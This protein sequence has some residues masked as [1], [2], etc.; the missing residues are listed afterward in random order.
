MEGTRLKT[1]LTEIHNRLAPKYGDGEAREM[2]RII[3]ENLKGWNPVDL[4][5]RRDELVS[6]YI[7]GKVQAVVNRLLDDEPIQQIFGNTR[8]YGLS[9]KVTTDT[10]I[11]RQETA[12][13]V[14][15]I[16]KENQR[17]DLRVLDAGT[18]TGCI[19]LAL[20]R[21]LNFPQVIATDISDKALAV[22][23]EN[24][25]ALRTNQVKFVNVDIL[26]MPSSVSQGI[27][28]S[29]SLP[30]WAGD[31][32]FDIIVSNPPYIAEH[33][34]AS[35]ERNVLDFEPHIALFVPDSD[36]LRFYTAI[37]SAAVSG[38]LRQGGKLY[39][40]INPIYSESLVSVARK[41]GLDNVSLI[42]DTN[43]KLRFLTATR[44]ATT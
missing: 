28:G 42:R 4:A 5:I 36:P 33:E 40:E 43:G 12:E 37:I 15:L 30:D 19:A 14:D 10:L 9:F 7:R 29:L 27:D 18:G 26:A 13:L 25:A 16:V 17:K 35:M 22:A 11:P 1:L 31:G 34:K 3:F 8:F 32:Q 23:R 6:D 24:A 21:N 2:G 20:Q 39:F 41:A 38:L 44:P